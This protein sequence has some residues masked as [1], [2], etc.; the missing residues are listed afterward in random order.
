MS[1]TAARQI[2]QSHQPQSIS[3]EESRL[4]DLGEAEAEEEIVR[5]HVGGLK[6]AAHV[7]AISLPGEAPF[8][9][10]SYW[11]RGE[12]MVQVRELLGCCT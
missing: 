6:V 12:L 11:W 8:A 2:C 3:S 10:S 1:M 4:D 5:R 7:H 9:P